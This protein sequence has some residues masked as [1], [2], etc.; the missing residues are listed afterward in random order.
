MTIVIVKISIPKVEIAVL[1]NWR[2][3]GE[4]YLPQSVRLLEGGIEML[5]GRIPYEHAV[6]LQ[7]ASL[8]HPILYNHHQ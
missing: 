7:G 2:I 4:K 8:T 5:F 3:F 6:S 1:K